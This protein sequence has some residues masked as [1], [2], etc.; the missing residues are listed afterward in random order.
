MRA[1]FDKIITVPI[2]PET[3]RKGIHQLPRQPDDANIIAVQLKRKLELKTTHL[4]EYIRP[5]L[6]VKALKYLKS[7]NTFYKNVNIDEDFVIEECN[8]V[9]KNEATQD[10]DG[11]DAKKQPDF[12]SQQEERSPETESQKSNE[13]ISASNAEKTEK[14]KD[15]DFEKFMELSQ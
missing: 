4:K 9:D 2:E 11:D 8:A 3:V 7:N 6:L 15:D 1:N 13:R 14:E 10:E 5:K 12:N